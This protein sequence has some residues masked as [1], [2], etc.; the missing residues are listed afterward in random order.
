MT[1]LPNLPR[2]TALLDVL[3]A[4][5][6]PEGRDA[7]AYDG[8]RIGGAGDAFLVLQR[9]PGLSG[10]FAQVLSV[11]GGY[12]LDHRDGAPVRLASS[13]PRTVCA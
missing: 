4:Q 9:I 7:D 2:N 10:V 3:R 8:R 12:T 11:T 5:G 1:V 6:V 13:R